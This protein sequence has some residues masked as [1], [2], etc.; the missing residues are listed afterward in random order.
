MSGARAR[1]IIFSMRS[2]L[3]LVFASLLPFLALHSNASLTTPKNLD[4]LVTF[5]S[6]SNAILAHCYTPEGAETPGIL[7]VDLESCREALQ[8]LVRTPDFA[9]YFRFSKNPRA[10]AMKVPAGWQLGA[11]AACRIIV[12]CQNDRDTAIFRYADVAQGARR[13]LDNC[14]DKPDPFGRYPL[15]KWGG[16]H[17]IKGGETFYVAVARPIVPGLELEVTNKTVFADGGLVDGGIGAS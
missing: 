11:D 17:G 13:I 7:P 4:S 5:N 14:V 9:T 6:S 3:R 8:V 2:K 15:L 16:V 1:E 10:M 12:T